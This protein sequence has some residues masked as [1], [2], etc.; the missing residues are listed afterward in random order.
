MDKIL[1][2]IT[3]HKQRTSTGQQSSWSVGTIL[4]TKDSVTFF[5]GEKRLKVIKI[6]LGPLKKTLISKYDNNQLLITGLFDSQVIAVYKFLRNIWCVRFFFCC[7]RE[8]RKLGY[9]LIP[10]IYTE[11]SIWLS[12]FL[13]KSWYIPIYK[14]AST[15]QWKWRNLEAI[16]TSLDSQERFSRIKSFLGNFFVIVYKL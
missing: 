13:T 12:T 1:T 8:R 9:S 2:Y 15:S 11:S 10:W 14:W 6:I 3:F 4:Y 7:A 5:V 16:V